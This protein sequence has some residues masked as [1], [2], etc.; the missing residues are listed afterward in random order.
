MVRY[1]RVVLGWNEAA[2]TG[3][4]GALEPRETG[5]RSSGGEEEDARVHVVS[6]AAIVPPNG[7]R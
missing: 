6:L 7:S 4:D 3:L 2:S 5:E 1:D